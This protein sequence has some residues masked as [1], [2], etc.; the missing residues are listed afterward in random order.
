VRSLRQE[1]LEQA[2]LCLV[3]EAQPHGRDARPLLEA[4]L[5]GGVDIVVLRDPDPPVETAEVF[6]DA[7]A[8]YDALLV[9][10]DRPDVALACGADGVHA[11][12][13][14]PGDARRLVGP[15]LLV[16]YSIRSREEILDARGA[17]YL[18]VGPVFET[19]SKPD[20]EPLGLDAVG[21]A[22]ERC[23]V[24]FFA[25]GGID[26]SNATAVVPA[27]A[28]RLGVVRAIRDAADPRAAAELLRSRL[29]S[30]I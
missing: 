27:G 3:L 29:D 12:E 14:S 9:V 28:R 13:L 26:S 11:E 5:A 10:T 25:I 19:P 24:P 1:R 15:E 7:T 2:R 16:G 17:D 23:P 22:A 30:T 8:A 21:L 4:A 20:W 18:F 6:R